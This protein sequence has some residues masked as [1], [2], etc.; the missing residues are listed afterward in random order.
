MFLNY[1]FSSQQEEGEH[2]FREEQILQLALALTTHSEL[3]KLKNFTP[4]T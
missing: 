1:I 4:R 3:R 2:F